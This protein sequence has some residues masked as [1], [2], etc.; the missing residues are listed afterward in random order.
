M[1]KPLRIIFAGVPDAGKSTLIG[2]ILLETNSVFQDQTQVDLAFYTD[3]LEDEQKN[4][5]TIDVAYRTIHL[6]SGRRCILIDTPGH[7]ELMSNFIS[8]ASYADVVFY[9]Q[10]STRPELES[11]HPKLAQSMGVPVYRIATKASLAETSLDVALAVDAVTN[12][13]IDALLGLMESLA[14][15]TSNGM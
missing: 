15:R 6:P 10:D 5:M 9:L 8:G 4:G 2:R 12:Y 13:N 14:Q 11:V 3:G 1:N 7:S